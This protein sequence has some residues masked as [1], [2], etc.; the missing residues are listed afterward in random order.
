MNLIPKTM[1]G[2]LLGGALLVGFSALNIGWLIGSGPLG[3]AVLGAATWTGW[4]GIR[5]IRDS[6]A[7]ARR[8]RVKRDRNGRWAGSR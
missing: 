5:T 6:R 8:R 4:V 7:K 2:R 3:W 1:E